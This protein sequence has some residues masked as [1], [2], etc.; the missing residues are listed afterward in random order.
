MEKLSKIPEFEND[1]RIAE[2][3]EAHNG[4]ELADQGLAEIAESPEFSGKENP[5]IRLDTETLQLLNELMSE[6]ICISPEDAI[7]KAVRS[8]ALAVLP[9]SYKLARDEISAR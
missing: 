9:H 5:G 1:Q 8:Y 3:M 6:G 4:F 2:F 7:G